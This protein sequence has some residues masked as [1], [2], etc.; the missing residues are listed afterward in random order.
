MFPTYKGLY[1][2]FYV[3]TYFSFKAKPPHYS[4]STTPSSMVGSREVLVGLYLPI[5]V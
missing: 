4:D 2:F 3:Q 1:P 5:G